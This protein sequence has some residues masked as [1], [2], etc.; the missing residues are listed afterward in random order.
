MDRR[1]FLKAGVGA[2]ATTLFW[3]A[4]RTRRTQAANTAGASWRTFEVTTR[5]EVGDPSGIT[6]VWLPLA[7]SSDTDYFKNLG[8]TWT[9]NAEQMRVVRDDPYGTSLFYAQWPEGVTAPVVEVTSRF[10]TRD[11]VVNPYGPGVAGREDKATLAKYLAATKLIKTDGIVRE[12]ALEI[13]R[14]AGSDLEKSRLVYEWIVDNTFRDPKV[15]GCGVGDIGWMLESGNLSGKC[16]DLN[17]LYVGLVRALGIPARDIYGVRAADSAE[18]KSLGKSG[19]VTKAQHCRAEFY[20]PSHGWI[21]VDPADVRKVVLEEPPGNIPVDD[22]K[23]VRARKKLF[24]AWEMNYLPFNYAHDVR[25]PG[26]EGLPIAFLMY[27]QAET[28][29][30][31]RDSLDPDTFRYRLTSRELTT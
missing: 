6:R 27:P 23:V 20:L 25:L 12:K 14:G 28:G 8:Q 18:F 5:A 2:S 15:R 3:S 10:T 29:G 17:A 22:P 11:R 21:P 13:T 26:S 31:R 24:G 16:A 7:L 9:G 30:D 4:P 19:D 1:A